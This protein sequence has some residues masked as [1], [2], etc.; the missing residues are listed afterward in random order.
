MTDKMR[1]YTQV[2]QM[3]K[4]QMPTTKQCFVVTLAMM[5]SGIVTGKKAQ[6][7]V[8]SAQIPSQAKPKSNEKRMR[9]FVKNESVDKTVFY[10]PFAEMILQQLA[11]HTLY[12]AIDG[13]TV[14]RGCMTIMVG[15]VY[16]QRMLPLAWLT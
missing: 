1:V 9:R 5:I 2:L 4:K 3:L 15:V 16:R 8:M 13:S 10:M 14:G 7:S 12:I 6:L 11:T